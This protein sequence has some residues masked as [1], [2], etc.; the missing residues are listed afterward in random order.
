MTIRSCLISLAAA[1]AS[2]CACHSS[3]PRVTVAPELPSEQHCWWAVYRTELPLDSVADRFRHAF[4]SIGLLPS[5][6]ARAGDTAWVDAGPSRVA[7]YRGSVAGRFV[8]YRA[9]DSTHFRLFVVTD[10]SSI[11]LCQQIL[12]AA[13][14]GAVALREPDGEEKLSVW[15]R[16]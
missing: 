13:P 5:T 16:R 3:R 14:V 6:Q 1:L 8:G 10:S 12:K 15:R 9:G 4:S 7:D 11:G 2:V